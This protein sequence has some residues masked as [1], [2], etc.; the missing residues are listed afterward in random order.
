MS[1]RT[2]N[3]LYGAVGLLVV[4]LITSPKL[5]IFESGPDTS[6]ANGTTDMRLPVSMTVMEPER[7]DD[8]IRSTGTVL[9]NEEVE[10]RSEIAG[11]IK[12]ILFKEGSRVGKGDL[13]VKIDDSELKAQLLKLQSQE[14]LAREV[15]IRRR[16]LLDSSLISSEEYERSLHELNSTRADIALTKARIDKTEIRAPFDGNV[17]IRFVS[18]GG[19]VTPAT[20]IASLQ[21]LAS[22]KIDFSIPERYVNDVRKGQ[23]IHFRLTG[24]SGSY[25]GEIYAVEPRIDPTTRTVLLRAIS[26]NDD[27]KIIPGAFAEIEL[28]LRQIDDALMVPT[29]AL[30]PELGRHIV[31]CVRDGQAQPREVTTGI[32]TERKIQILS[33]LQRQDTVITSGILQLRPGTP[34]RRATEDRP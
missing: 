13:L 25:E 31:Y 20:R 23:K 22:V 12:R 24:I 18:E 30:I 28:I 17:G 15:E 29:E 27:G 11:I 2:R 6:A 34:V 16:S 1:K 7:V 9:A 8:R 4:I 19:Y 14:K 21:N 32:R 3:I 26:S 10:L 33:G 5:S